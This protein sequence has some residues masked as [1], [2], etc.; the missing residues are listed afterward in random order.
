MDGG[1]TW[2]SALSL[3][4][5]SRLRVAVIRVA[6]LAGLGLCAAPAVASAS[7]SAQPVSSPFSQWGDA[8]SY[9]PVPGGSFEGTADQLG[10]TLSGASLTS[11]NEPFQVNG[12]GDGQSLSIAGEGS[13]TSPF[14]CVDKTMTSLRFFAQQTAA[15]GDLQ[16]N[17]LVQTPNGVTTVPA[18]ALA[19]GSMPS[20]APTEPI[21]GDTGNMSDDQSFMVA[22]QFSVPA[23]AAGWQIDDLYVDPYRSG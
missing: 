10:W 4:I 13:A 17:A 3:L 19:D 18:G 2:R 14:F 15:G 6:I 12:S 23:S 20:W 11:G 5:H 7:C 16:V 21:T 9:F 1:P 22:L 8:N